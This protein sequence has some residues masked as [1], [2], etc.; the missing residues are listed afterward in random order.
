MKH[1]ARITLAIP[2]VV[3]AIAL[4]VLTVKLLRPEE[5]VLTGVVECT[6]V[7]VAAKIPGRVDSICAREGEPV[8]AGALLAQ[9]EGKEM[10]AKVGQARSAMAA[11]RA[12]MEMALAG[13][14]PEER[15]AVT[16]QYEQARAQFELAE[17][18]WTRVERVYRDSLISTQERDQVEFQFTA[19]REQMDAARAKMTMVNNG[20]RHEEIAAAT[21]LFDQATNAYRGDGLLR[22][23]ATSEPH[24]W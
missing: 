12:K 24:Q 18:T 11:A 2:A 16:R 3:V 23:A 22:G 17:K 7:D 21:A 13:A 8:A 19:A 14:R 9:L 5:P 4:I 15:D 10:D 20:A 6:T 1:R